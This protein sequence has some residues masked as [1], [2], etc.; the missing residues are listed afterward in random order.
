MTASN[1]FLDFGANTFQGLR[2]FGQQ[3]AMGSDW[4]CIAY[5]ANPFIYQRALGQVEAVKK[6]LGLASLELYPYA[7]AARD[8]ET[9][10]SCILG[11]LDADGKIGLISDFGGSSIIQREDERFNRQ[12]ASTK[13]TVHCV[14][15]NKIMSQ[16]ALVSPGVQVHIKCDIEGAEYDVIPRLLESSHLGMLKSAYIEWHPRYWPETKQLMRA[17]AEA[18][19]EELRCRGVQVFR[20]W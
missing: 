16:I 3:L 11:E 17:K 20:H 18:L 15:V 14:D 10:M 4:S 1:L 7:V 2:Y 8:G 5:E 13:E 6:E 19:M 12:L 9:E